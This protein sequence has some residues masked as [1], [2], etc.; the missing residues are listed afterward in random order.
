MQVRHSK[1]IN[2]KNK[3]TVAAHGGNGSFSIKSRRRFESLW[4]QVTNKW[5]KYCVVSLTGCHGKRRYISL[6]KKE[7]NE[8]M[9]HLMEGRLGT[10]ST[11]GEQP[12]Y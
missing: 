6:Y 8:Q 10:Y 1:K 2:L 3:G 5:L 7:A 11:P 4:R 9:R 12:T